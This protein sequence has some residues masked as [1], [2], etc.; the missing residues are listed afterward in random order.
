MPELGDGLYID[1]GVLGDS[2]KLKEFAKVAEE[3][4]KKSEE[5]NKKLQKQKKGIEEIVKGFVGVASA[6]TGA[7]IALDRLTSSLAKQN[8]VWANINQQTSLNVKNIQAAAGVAASLNAN[9]TR[10]SAAGVFGELN[11][12]LFNLRLTGEGARGFQIAGIDPRGLDAE[13]V[14]EKVRSRIKGLSNES[15]TFLLEQ[16]GISPELLPM[17]RLTREE[18][19]KLRKEQEKYTFSEEQVR[20]IQQYNLQLKLAHQRMQYLKDKALLAIMPHFVRFMEVF[21]KLTESVAKFIYKSRGLIATLMRLGSLL[22]LSRKNKTISSVLEK[23]S[24]LSQLK[25]FTK[26]AEVF[27]I[28]GKEL[29]GMIT[30]IPIIG[31][32]L[33]KLFGSVGKWFFKYFFWLEAIYLIIDDIIGYFQGKNSVTGVFIDWIK[34]IFSG[35]GDAF[36]KFS[37]GDIAGGFGEIWKTLKFIGE[38][39]LDTIVRFAGYFIN[40]DWMV[41]QLRKYFESKT[42][43]RPNLKTPIIKGVDTSNLDQEQINRY[44]EMAQRALYD[45]SMYLDKATKAEMR[46]NL[47]NLAPYATALPNTYETY[48]NG[49]NTTVTQNNYITTN[50]PANDINKELTHAMGSGL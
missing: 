47:K 7:V 21:S 29:N 44:V 22:Y 37:E 5:I 26:F 31:G 30:K 19:V 13:G 20:A 41:D 2:K 28:V 14:L 50:Q 33:S 8:Q 25:A 4:A 9:L 27:K 18:Y 15:A 12:R 16:M 42:N 24:K 10:E 40:T 34:D 49:G 43:E 39:I 3:I 45:D 6:V 32:M 48:N 46:E 11:K 36:K 35:F 1:L 38:S 17:L 23:L